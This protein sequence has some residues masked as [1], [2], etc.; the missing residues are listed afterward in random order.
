MKTLMT[1]MIRAYQW[2]LSPLL[3]NCC[4]FQPSCSAYALEAVQR[5][6]WLKGSLLG[7]RRLCR[8]HPFCPAGDDPVPPVNKPEEPW[9]NCWTEDMA[10]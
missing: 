4:R 7:I 9:Q 8:C 2:T 6:G 3:G 10:K 1:I 5:H